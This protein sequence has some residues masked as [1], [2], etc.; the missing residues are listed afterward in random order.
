[1]ADKLIYNFI[2]ATGETIPL[3]AVEVSTGVYA[4]DTVEFSVFGATDDYIYN[5][6]DN[7]GEFVPLAVKNNGDDSFSLYINITT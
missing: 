4:L 1:M 7:A 5:F 3:K 2:N 6:V